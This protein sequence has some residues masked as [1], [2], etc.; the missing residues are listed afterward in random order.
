MV[1][2]DPAK[3]GINGQVLYRFL[4]GRR[5]FIAKDP[6][7][8]GPPKASEDRGMDI[9]RSIGIF[10]M[11]PVMGRPPKGPLLAATGSPKGHQELEEAAGLIGPVRKIAMI[12]A[13]D[14]EHAGEI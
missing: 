1:F 8:M 13:R 14:G 4:V 6:S 5:V 12:N 2:V 9:L 10:V 11:M 3:L 7:H